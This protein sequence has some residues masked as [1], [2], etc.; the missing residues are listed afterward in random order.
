MCPCDDVHYGT[1]RVDGAVR[2][3][4]GG[5][6]GHVRHRAAAPSPSSES[7]DGANPGADTSADPGPDPGEFYTIISTRPSNKPHQTSLLATFKNK[8]T[9]PF[10]SPSL[11]RRRCVPTSY[12]TYS[13][14]YDVQIVNV[15]NSSVVPASDKLVLKSTYVSTDPATTIAWSASKQVGLERI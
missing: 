10:R 15:V 14:P 9:H 5:K 4:R 6:R 8:L 1:A 13:P 12:P 11:P 3:V 2:E 7:D